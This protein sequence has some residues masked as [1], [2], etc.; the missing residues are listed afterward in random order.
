MESGG[1]YQRCARH[2]ASPRFTLSSDEV[3][4]VP[5]GADQ[6]DALL[7]ALAALRGFL[8]RATEVVPCSLTRTEAGSPEGWHGVPR[9]VPHAFGPPAE[10]RLIKALDEEYDRIMKDR[11]GLEHLRRPR[12]SR[13]AIERLLNQPRPPKPPEAPETDPDSQDPS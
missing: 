12:L 6:L 2:E 8:E 5:G 1:A 10:Q 4:F 7:M 13:E 9:W 3:Y 11:V